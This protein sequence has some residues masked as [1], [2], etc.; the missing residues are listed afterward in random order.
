MRYWLRKA[1]ASCHC[2]SVVI[3]ENAWS[4]HQFDWHI[5]FDSS[6]NKDTRRVIRILISPCMAVQYEKNCLLIFK[7]MSDMPSPLSKASGHAR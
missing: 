3:T 2:S 4:R 7:Q 1:E 5:I 6:T